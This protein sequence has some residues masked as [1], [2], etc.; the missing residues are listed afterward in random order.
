MFRKLGFT[1]AEIRELLDGTRSLADVLPEN[2]TR[3]EAREAELAAARDLC[4]DMERQG[5]SMDSFD[6]DLWFEQIENEESQGR[7]FLDLVGDM[8][9]D[10]TRTMAFM[11]D[12]I[13]LHGPAY[14]LF[15]FSEEGIRRRR[16]WKFYWFI[17]ALNYLIQLGISRLSLGG[18]THLAS[19]LGALAFTVLDGIIGSLVLWLCARY[20]IPG[21]KPRCALWLIAAI[22]LAVDLCLLPL[23]LQAFRTEVD[24]EARNAWLSSAAAGTYVGDDPRA[25]VQTQFNDRY[26]GGRAELDVW[27]NDGVLFVFTSWGTVFQ[28]RRTADGQ[29]A[30]S[31]INYAVNGKLYTAD[32]YGPRQYSSR[33]MLTDGT[34]AAPVYEARFSNGFVPLYAFDVSAGQTYTGVEYGVDGAGS[35][36]YVCDSLSYGGSSDWTPPVNENERKWEHDL[37]EVL[38]AAEG[39]AFLAAYGAW[40]TAVLAA[41]PVYTIDSATQGVRSDCVMWAS[42]I[43]PPCLSIG[44]GVTG[45]AGADWGLNEFQE[46]LFF[47]E[48][49]PYL[50]WMMTCQADVLPLLTAE[51]VTPALLQTAANSVQSAI[52]LQGPAATPSLPN[53][54]IGDEW[55]AFTASRAYLCTV[56]DALSALGGAVFSELNG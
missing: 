47:G 32:P 14:A 31:M 16:L 27:Q 36:H 52:L 2:I 35:L 10:I 42:Y 8:A 19:P 4:R 49:G 41:E 13:G 51:T 28:F 48:Q 7:R 46:Q 18:Y 12:S 43:A 44:E 25:Y 30:E 39:P 53:V 40:R 24:E 1:V 23:Y 21:R 54:F 22:L 15:F 20:I 55:L 9:D 33:L 34:V 38:S 11:Q 17:L 37:Q 50:L 3:L 29:W 6:P 26:Y 5:L 45:A 56:P